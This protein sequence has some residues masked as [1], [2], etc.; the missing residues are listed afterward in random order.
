M[1]IVAIAGS[2]RKGSFN[3]SLL[4]TLG[5]MMPA[6]IALEIQPLD[7]VPLYNEDLEAKG[8]PEPVTRLW[9]A[10][11]AADGL[12]VATPEYNASVPGVLKNSI[13]WLS[14]P[15]GKSVLK[16]KPA[17]VVGVS[18]GVLGTVRAQAHVRAAL[19]YNAA[20]VLPSPQV[21]IGQARDKFDGEGR[22]TDEKTRTFL[23]K[24]LDAYVVWVRRFAQP[25]S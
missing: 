15:P 25:V 1:R 11:G 3:R 24:F 21:F 9:E 20:P 8:T 5:E 17:G 19:E 23:A 14:R 10:I 16:G 4:F 7:E 2:L 12:L 22:L 13:D 18:T 6:G